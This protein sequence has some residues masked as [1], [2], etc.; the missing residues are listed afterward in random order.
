MSATTIYRRTIVGSGLKAK[1][2]ANNSKALR[3]AFFGCEV[4]G[5]YG[6]H[7]HTAE[8]F[9]DLIAASYSK[10][11]SENE[12][13]NLE[14]ELFA[15]S[16]DEFTL[17]SD[18]ST[19]DGVILPGSFSSAYQTDQEW[20]LSL[21]E[22]IQGTLV[23]KTV[24]TLGV[25]FGHQLYAHSFEDGSARKCPSGPQAGRK[26]TALTPTGKAFF[27][28]TDINAV[29]GLDLYYTHGDMVERLPPTGVSLGGNDPVP[30]QAA[31]YFSSPPQDDAAALLQANDEN[32]KVIAVTFQAHPEF[33]SAEEQLQSLGEQTFC[34]T[35]NLM[36]DNGDLSEQ[37]HSVA[38]SDAETSCKHVNQQSLDAM[39]AA[40]KLLGW[41][42]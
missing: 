15:A 8:L 37:D 23:A 42:R 21:K 41:F 27:D 14:L 38:L 3:L 13:R 29:S 7:K 9:C 34:K 40:G 28:L 22:Y 39:V 26:T 20:I 33:A 32:N 36:R 25:C 12:T 6:P 35:V 10:V 18:L 11:L 30:I 1:Q 19:F 2:Q 24:P 31:V 16:G 17:P 5:P 4:K